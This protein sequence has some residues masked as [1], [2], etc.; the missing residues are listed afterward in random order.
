MTAITIDDALRIAADGDAVLFVGAGI[1]FLVEGPNGALPDG[2][3]LSNRVLGRSDN[4][5]AAPPLDKAVGYAIRRLGGAEEVYRTLINNISV[6]NVD[7]RLAELYC[8]PW[9]RIYTTN[10]DD[11]IEISRKGRQPTNSCVLETGTDKAKIGTILHINGQLS[12]V[13]PASLDRELSLSDRSYADRNLERSPW[14]AHLARDLETARAVIFIGYSLYDL[15]IS[16][17]I[18]SSSIEEKTFFYVS[19]SIDEIEEESLGLYGQTPGGGALALI[20]SMEDTLKEYTPISRRR[21]YSSLLRIGEFE[22]GRSS[23]PARLIDAQLVFGILPE[24]EVIGGTPVFSDR[25]FIVQRKQQL[26]AQDV[27]RRGLYRDVVVTGEFASGK[28][29]T[30]LS[31]VADFIR[32]GYRAYRAVHGTHLADELTDLATVDDRIVLVFEGYSTFRRTIRDYARIRNAKHRLVLTEQAVQHELFGEFV[33]EPVFG[34]QFYE[35]TLDHIRGEDATQ[36][37]ELIDFGG[38]W[39][40]RSGASD[41]TNARYISGPLQGSLYRLLSEIVESEDVRRRIDSIIGPILANRRATEVFVAASIVNILGVQFRASDWVG[42]FDPQFVNSVLRNYTDEIKYFLLVQSGHVFP[43]S[44]LLSSSILRR[45]PDRSVLVEAAVKLYTVA[46]RAKQPYDMYDDVYVRLMQFN[47]LQPMMKGDNEKELIFLFYENIRP[48]S[49]THKNADYWLQL[50]IAAS[51]FDELGIAG[52]AFENAYAR[53][54]KKPR[55]NFKRIDNYYN[56]YLLKYSA[57]L[58]DSQDA[59]E[60]F[61]EATTGLTKQM[62]LE[63]NRHYPFKSGRLYGEIAKK[64]FVNW[65]EDQQRHFV[66]ETEEIR[67]KAIEYD[68]KHKGQSV[69]VEVLI[70]ETSDLLDRLTRK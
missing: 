7:P 68:M 66:K 11:A 70:R 15:D 1:G 16:R 8:L 67:A 40:E 9:R 24:P 51:A 55:P 69:D 5:T 42:A 53:E 65:H 6:K 27:L 28:S 12:R 64:H 50:G 45:I 2:A 63:D 29:A 38:Y 60:L 23:E 4:H 52:D 61:V 20:K 25:Q 48:I 19:P 31:L 18:F 43:R 13:S 26:D 46:V 10:Y 49:N 34:G 32:Q 21:Q 62:F 37:A 47:R 33:Y 41:E 57:F 35:I 39:R 17:L 56:R 30:A 36:F 44:G 14:Y 3:A 54:K 58:A 59:Y 22:A